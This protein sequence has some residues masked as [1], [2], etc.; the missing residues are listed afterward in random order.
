MPQK[1]SGKPEPAFLVTSGL[2]PTPVE[3]SQ[4]V[5]AP[6][7]GQIS[8]MTRDSKA[9]GEIW[10]LRR[11]SDWFQRKEFRQPGSEHTSGGESSG[12]G[13]LAGLRA[14]GLAGLATC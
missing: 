12:S 2:A 10:P 7:P 1:H 8:N 6:N 11:V 3:T 13:F 5:S 9:V 4:N 14:Q